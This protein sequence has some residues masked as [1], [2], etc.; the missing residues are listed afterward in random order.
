VVHTSHDIYLKTYKEGTTMNVKR[1]FGILVLALMIGFFS[2]IN[3]FAKGINGNFCF[4]VHLTENEDGPCDETVTATVHL[5]SVDSSTV[6]MSGSISASGTVYLTGI[7]QV[8]GDVVTFNVQFTQ[9]ISAKGEKFAGTMQM[10]LDKSTLSGT[11]W[12]IQ[13]SYSTPSSF[14]NEYG[15]GTITKLPKCP[16]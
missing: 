4:T 5:K 12:M 1:I 8:A 11:F 3:V 15:A 2:S 16:K 9:N 6:T 10:V 7:G 14:E 13:Q